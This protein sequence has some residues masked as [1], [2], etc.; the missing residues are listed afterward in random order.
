MI[1]LLSN[2]TKSLGRF[3]EAW[4]EM[5]PGYFFVFSLQIINLNLNI[6][7]INITIDIF[8]IRPYNIDVDDNN[9]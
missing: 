3:P 4:R 7:Y 8:N 1:E 9:I 2:I 6:K 5:L